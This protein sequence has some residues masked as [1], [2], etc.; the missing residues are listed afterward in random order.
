MDC[1]QIDG[2]KEVTI[3]ECEGTERQTVFPEESKVWCDL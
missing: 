1:I 3:K 2:K